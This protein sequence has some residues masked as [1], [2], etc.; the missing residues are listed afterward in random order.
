MNVLDGQVENDAS[1][2][3]SEDLTDMRLDDNLFQGNEINE[4]HNGDN[5][6]A[7]NIILN[8]T[9]T[10]LLEKSYQKEL[11]RKNSQ[12]V[13][14]SREISKLKTFIS[15]RK[16][17]YKR[18][19]KDE[20]APTRALSAYNI[21][22]RER[23]SKLAKENDEALRSSDADVHLKRVPPAS[24]VASTGNQW[25]ELSPEERLVYEEKAAEDKKRY[26]NQM[27]VYQAPEKQNNKKRSRTGYNIFFTAH[28]ERLKQT[29][30][31]VPSERGSCAR[32]VG[33]AWKDLSLEEK[34]YYENEA[35]R[36]NA[37]DA[38][39]TGDEEFKSFAMKKSAPKRS[40]HSDNTH[41][42]SGHNNN[43]VLHQHGGGISMHQMISTGPHHHNM[44]TPHGLSRQ[45]YSHS[46]AQ[47]QPNHQT[48]GYQGY[49]PQQQHPSYS[50]HLDN[51]RGHVPHY[52][53]HGHSYHH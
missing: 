16:Q 28:V 21:F 22:I 43:G 10:T 52:S 49:P 5:D 15:K 19:R 47:Y 3:N 29:E 9:P 33:N 39:D 12:L 17:T 42:N 6:D 25:K 7:Q 11:E 32:I 44:D 31:G 2:G 53:Q 24:L 23:F 34:Q 37:H 30:A 38:A 51:P 13:Q 26:E 14:L 46:P 40:S 36:Q 1:N 27:A 41:P 50:P 35:E 4:S 45:I 8:S 20:G 48:I 18:K